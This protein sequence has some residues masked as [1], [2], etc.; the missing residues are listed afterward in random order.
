M[1]AVAR[2]CLTCVIGLATGKA[3]PVRSAWRPRS[4]P[5]ACS[6]PVARRR[7]GA[8]LRLPPGPGRSSSSNAVCSADPAAMGGGGRSWPAVAGLGSARLSAR[9]P[10]LIDALL[11]QAHSWRLGEVTGR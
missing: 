11:A 8:L 9:C 2:P 7:R 1:Q 6:L 5:S 4:G 10:W 3:L